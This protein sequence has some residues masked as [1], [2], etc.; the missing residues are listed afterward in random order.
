MSGKN[1]VKIDLTAATTATDWEGLSSEASWRTGTR[2]GTGDRVW[3]SRASCSQ[4]V[5]WSEKENRFRGDA[6]LINHVK[7][8]GDVKGSIWKI[9]KENYVFLSLIKKS[10]EKN[11]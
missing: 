5:G 3:T 10:W 8:L 6:I 4:K 9:K 11:I 2:A 7:G 1:Y